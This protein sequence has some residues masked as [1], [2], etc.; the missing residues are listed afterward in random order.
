M[1]E[2]VWRGQ[3]RAPADVVGWLKDQAKDR[4]TSL[5]TIMVEALREYQKNRMQAAS[6]GKKDAVQ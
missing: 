3:V 5:N 2:N 1:E 4:F 6:E